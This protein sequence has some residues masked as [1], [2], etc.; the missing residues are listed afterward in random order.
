V[1]IFDSS[2]TEREV[3]YSDSYSLR[4]SNEDS[5]RGVTLIGMRTVVGLRDVRGAPVLSY[6]AEHNA[7]KSYHY[8]NGSTY[9]IAVLIQDN[10]QVLRKPQAWHRVSMVFPLPHHLDPQLVRATRIS[11]SSFQI[12]LVRYMYLL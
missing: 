10:R 7:A 3:I 4:L 11:N 5:P 8:T 9:F 2:I 6:R 12:P 1:G